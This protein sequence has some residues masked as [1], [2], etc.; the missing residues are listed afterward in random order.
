MVYYIQIIN[1]F[2]GILEKKFSFPIL[3]ETSSV[4]RIIIIIVHNKILLSQYGIIAVSNAQTLSRRK[5]K[6][7]AVREK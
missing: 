2:R 5:L 4:F 7:I 1:R 6:L 3:M